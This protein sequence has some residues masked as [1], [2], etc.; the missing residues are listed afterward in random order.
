M[1]LKFICFYYLSSVK[2]DI[3]EQLTYKRDNINLN[4]VKF[5]LLSK[6]SLLNQVS[7]TFKSYVHSLEH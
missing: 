6:L 3:K 7:F 1:M 2:K 5:H 4:R